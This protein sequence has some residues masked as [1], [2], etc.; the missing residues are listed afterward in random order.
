M[1]KTQELIDFFIENQKTQGNFAPDIRKVSSPKVWQPAF[2]TK[3]M[4]MLNLAWDRFPKFYSRIEIEEEIRQLFIPNKG[5]WD[6][7]YS[8]WSLIE[9]NWLEGWIVD[10]T[11]FEKYIARKLRKS[12]PKASFQ[13]EEDMRQNQSK[14]TPDISMKL[15]GIDWIV[16]CVTTQRF[17][18][19]DYS[20][21]QVVLN[22]SYVVQASLY[23]Y[24]KDEPDKI[25]QRIRNS[26]EKKAKRYKNYVDGKIYIIAIAPSILGYRNLYAVDCCYPQGRA[27]IMVSI[28]DKPVGFRYEELLSN[29][30]PLFQ[31][32]PH[33]SGVWSFS[34]RERDL[35]IP[36]RWADVPISDRLTNIETLKIRGL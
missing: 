13:Y 4:N 3:Q 26:I 15:N 34:M 17:R 19:D 32:Y 31:E 6:F 12:F 7:F 33:I 24:Q 10:D 27:S 8:C 22:N 11:N 2:G 14:V 18:P 20:F 28:N 1:S 30:K 5:E 25:H 35:F 29:W 16:E 23:Q 9:T 21:E 36:N